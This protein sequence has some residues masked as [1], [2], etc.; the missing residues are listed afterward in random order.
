MKKRMISIIM[1]LILFSVSL[2]FL[3]S[4]RSDNSPASLH[5]F[6]KINKIKYQKKAPNSSFYNDYQ[7]PI[8]I[9]KGDFSNVIGWLNDSEIIYLTNTQESS[10]LYIYNLI[11][12]NSKILYE[13]QH[14]IILTLISPDRENI[15]IHSSPTTYEGQM[16]IINKEGEIKYKKEFPSVEMAFEWNQ[17]NSNQLIVTTFKADWSFS[18][19]LLNIDKEAIEPLDIR[20]PFVKWTGVNK[21]AFL[22][23]DENDISLLSPLKEKELNKDEVLLKENIFQFESYLNKILTIAYDGEEE[24]AIYTFYSNDMKNASAIKAPILSNYS[25]WL[26]PYYELSSDQ[27]E[28]LTM[29]PFESTDADAYKGGFQFISYNLESG[30]KEIIL[31]NTENVPFT[32]SPNKQYCLMGYQ[33]E[34]LFNLKRKTFTP[35]F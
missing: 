25:G 12:G 19:F 4:C 8:S 7:L 10:Y 20:K 23:W 31:E 29:L 6:S 14:P 1:V 21:L 17:Y 27:K 24:L 5:S 33:L 26:I 34:K 18:N 9:T 16:T 22:D 3:T 35:L 13:S 2:S 30:N 15:L 32:C 11:K 28:F